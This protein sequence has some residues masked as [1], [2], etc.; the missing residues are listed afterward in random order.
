MKTRNQYPFIYPMMLMAAHT[1]ARRSELLRSERTDFD[2]AAN[3]VT[4]REK[5]RAKGR[6]TCRTVPLTP[7]LRR[8]IEAVLKLGSGKFTF[9]KVGE[10]ISI[11]AATHGLKQTLAG[12][13]WEKIAGWHVFRH[14]FISICASRGIDQR[15]IDAWVGHQTEEI[16]RRYRHLFPDAQLTALASAFG[17]T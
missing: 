3:T 5:K 14:S 16:R 11:D 9:S 17:G 8:V 6:K 2:F 4:I 15:M 1:G 12:S 10:P 7:R 13:R